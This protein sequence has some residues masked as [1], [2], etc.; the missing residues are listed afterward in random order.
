MIVHY[1]SI[2]VRYME[3]DYLNK[4]YKRT[5]IKYKS[6]KIWMSS[7]SIK[8]Q[9]RTF[10]YTTSLTWYKSLH[11]RF[12]MLLNLVVKPCRR[13]LFKTSF[14]FKQLKIKIGKL[15]RTERSLLKIENKR[16]FLWILLEIIKLHTQRVFIQRDIL[17]STYYSLMIV[18]CLTT[19]FCARNVCDWDFSLLFFLYLGKPVKYFS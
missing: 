11:E 4:S 7:R 10:C 15:L 18:G 17:E 2:F 8:V 14:Y 3:K 12:D 16:I 1:T 6:Y 13:L 5:L 19:R 9:S